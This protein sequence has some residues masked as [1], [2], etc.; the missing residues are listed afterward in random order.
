MLTRRRFL[1]RGTAALA[2]LTGGTYALAQLA[3]QGD[4]T[5][6]AMPDGSASKGMI[7]D[8]AQHAIDRGLDYLQRCQYDD[9]S[10]GTGPIYYGDVAI[11]SLAALAMMAGGHQPGRGRY[12]NV[13]THALDYVLSQEDTTTPGFLHRGGRRSRNPMYSH[14][15]G[16]LFLSEVY[17]MVQDQ[18]R[19]KALRGTLTRAVNLIIDRQ[20]PRGG[21]RYYPW[22]HDADLSVTIC[23]IMALRAARNAGFFVPKSTVDLCVNY[24][25][26]CQ[27]R[28][29]SFRYMDVAGNGFGPPFARTAAGVVALYSA[30]IYDGLAIKR[31]LDFLLRPECLPRPGRYQDANMHYFYGHY[32]AV[33]AMWTAGGHYWTTWF[34]A[35]REELI[36]RQRSDGFWYD[37]ICSHYGT[38]MACIILQIPN[39]YLPIFER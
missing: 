32:Y 16:T 19:R 37:Q 27:D 36:R 28:D 1:S 13:V 25:K 20:N 14:G 2:A 29:G 6:E 4:P 24:V 23:Q 7:T 11:T 35:I 22:S 39:N 38:A 34:P 18:R 12:G 3:Q 9:G 30:G 31:G 10:F 15:F 21:W 17:G 5:H 26:R 33:Q 8:E